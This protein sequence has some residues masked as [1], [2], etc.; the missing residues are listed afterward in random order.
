M[1]ITVRQGDTLWYYSQLF[2]IPLPLVEDSNPGVNVNQLQ[3]GMQVLLPGYRT[4]TY[5]IQPN[6]S[7]WTIAITN[8]IPVDSI[9]LLNPTIQPMNLQIGKTILLPEKVRSAIITD[10]NKYTYEK[11]QQ[12]LHNLQAIYPFM[13]QQSIGKSVMGKEIVE[14]QIGRGSNDVHLNGSFHG[15]EWITTS[16]IMK[17][18]NEY[19]LSLTNHNPIRGRFTLPLYQTTQLSVVPMV[20]PDG[21]NLVINGAKAAGDYETKVLEMNHQNTNFSNWKANIKGVDLNKQYPA[22]WETEVERKPTSPQPRDF[23]GYAPMTEPEAITMADLANERNYSIVNALHTQGEEIYWGFEGLEPPESEQ[24]VNEYARVSGYLP[25]Q[26]IDSYAGY[27]DW[28]IQ[29]F[30]KPGFTIELGTGVNPLP[31]EQF[32]EIYEETLGIL[33]ANL[34]L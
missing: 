2:G 7:L 21:V 29:E 1:E 4:I 19:A 25:V 6:D 17:F 18:I 34:Y 24:I 12:D 5:S 11:F 9:A 31:F 22:R 33:L 27:R 16:V 26:Y 28:F 15:N 10:L 32:P 20:N 8:N 23:P 3:P 13:F 14:L 30:R